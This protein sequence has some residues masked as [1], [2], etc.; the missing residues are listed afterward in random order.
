MIVENIHQPV[1]DPSDEFKQMRMELPSRE[2]K[3][4]ENLSGLDNSD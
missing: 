3:M 1:W 2:F 4:R